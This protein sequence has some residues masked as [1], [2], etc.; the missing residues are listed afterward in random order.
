MGLRQVMEIE[1]HVTTSSCHHPQLKNLVCHGAIDG[2]T[3]LLL[4]C[5]YGELE[6]VQRIV[7][8]WEVDVRTSAS[9]YTHIEPC[10]FLDEYNNSICLVEELNSIGD[11]KISSASPLLVAAINGR[12]SIVRYLVEKG[13]DVLAKSGSGIDPYEDLTPLH[14]AIFGLRSGGKSA[15]HYDSDSQDRQNIADIARCLLEAGADPN[16]LTCD[17]IPIWMKSNCGAEAAKALIN[18]GLDLTQRDPT[19]SMTILN[20]WARRTVDVTEEQSLSVVKLLVDQ[21]ADLLA[22]DRHGLTPILTAAIGGITPNFSVLDYLLKR[23][24]VPR[25]DKIIALELVGSVILGTKNALHYLKGAMCWRRALQLRQ[26]ETE[27]CGPLNKTPLKFKNVKTVEWVTAAELEDVI[28]YPSKYPIQSLFIQL[29]FVISHKT[30]KAF[31]PFHLTLLS[32]RQEFVESIGLEGILD[33]QLT[34]FEALSHHLVPLDEKKLRTTTQWIERTFQTFVEMLSLL[35]SNDPLLLTA[36]TIDNIATSLLLISE[37]DAFKLDKVFQLVTLLAGRPQMVTGKV[38]ESLKEFVQRGRPTRYGTSLIA[39]AC[40]TLSTSASLVTVLRLLLDFG[41]DPNP[42]GKHEDSPLHILAKYDGEVVDTTA[43]LLLNKGAHFD[44]VNDY[45]KS[46]L[47]VWIERNKGA[48]GWNDRPN[49]LRESVPPPLMCQCTRVI[50]D[51]RVPYS[52]L[53]QNLRHFVEIHLAK[54]D[55]Y[56]TGFYDGKW[57]CYSHIVGSAYF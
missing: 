40:R 13:A 50:R 45:G 15:V 31:N 27:E 42:A 3:P 1:N 38:K 47:D 54:R 21:G 48:K 57:F 17:Q 32:R 33:M 44:R 53:P 16:A 37:T 10:Y 49:W 19:S 5:S 51:N 7:E 35:Q 30:W 52:R 41:A 36:E 23:N 56:E 2:T 28:Q 25:M 4:A 8:F 12:F 43:K 6:A 14:G 46:A 24:D 29:R 9:Y 22:R 26:L 55:F 11:L 34:L 18:H 20:F 39:R